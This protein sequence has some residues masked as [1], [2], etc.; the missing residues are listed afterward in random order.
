VA[1]LK[2]QGIGLAGIH[3]LMGFSQEDMKRRVCE[4]LPSA[5]IAEEKS[6]RFSG[7]LGIPVEAPDLSREF[8]EILRNPRYGYGRNINP[9]ID[10]KIF[11]MRKA[12]ERMEALNAD[13]VFTGEVLGQR[14][15]SQNREALRTVERESGLVGRL[16]RP[17]SAR[18]L[19]PTE[20]EQ[21]GIVDRAKLL[22]IQGRSRKRQLEL[23]PLLG[24]T[25]YGAPA[26]GCALTDG[27]FARRYL[28]RARH[29]G[30]EPPAPEDM[31][32]MSMGRHLRISPRTLLVVG[33]NLRE[34]EY[35][36]SVWARGPLAS[37]PDHPGPTVLIIGD[38]DE[39]DL[40]AAASVTARYSDGKKMPSVKV[41]VS[42]G[43]VTREFDAAPAGD[44][45]LGRWRI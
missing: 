38:P 42:G 16:L 5:Q 45:D 33:R 44:G 39:A 12:R 37:T 23:A 32:L 30:P 18:L 15:M 22:D 25:G 31:V 41:I 19:P 17:L 40:E 10:C 28:D 29:P 24:V 4:G 2:S 35:L 6:R 13:F 21:K 14:P 1:V 27:N 8:L 3:V 9:C 34:N 7:L 20:A 26:G 36:E 11:M 43:G